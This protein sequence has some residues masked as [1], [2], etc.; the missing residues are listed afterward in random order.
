MKKE[1]R[2]IEINCSHCGN[3]FYMKGEEKGWTVNLIG[4][5]EFTCP[6]GQKIILPQDILFA[7]DKTK[8]V[9]KPK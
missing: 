4:N 1:D 8:K 9:N 5:W 6:C 3:K 2:Q 7:F